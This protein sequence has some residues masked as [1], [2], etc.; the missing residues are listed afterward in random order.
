MSVVDITD[1]Y[2]A[3]SVA[4]AGLVATIAIGTCFRERKLDDNLCGSI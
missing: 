1:L 4:L 2:S 3:W